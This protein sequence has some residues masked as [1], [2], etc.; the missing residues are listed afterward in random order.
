MKEAFLKELML[1][2]GFTANGFGYESPYS[3]MYYKRATIEF[4]YQ[5]R[6]NPMYRIKDISRSGTK[7]LKSWRPMETAEAA[8]QELQGIEA[9]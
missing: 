8:L 9:A 2:Y 5:K 6:A 7:V 4:S 1:K 3:I